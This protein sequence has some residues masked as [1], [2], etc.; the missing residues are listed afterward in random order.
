MPEAG[1]PLNARV[2]RVDTVDRQEHFDA[3]GGGNI[4]RIFYVEPYCAHKRVVIALKGTVVSSNAA[5]PN[6]PNAT[7]S[8]VKPHQDPLYPQFYCSDV[9]VVPFNK[10]SSLGGPSKG[11]VDNPANDDAQTGQ[12]KAIRTALDWVDD[13]DGA[14]YIDN[15]TPSEIASGYVTVNPDN[16]S[17][18]CNTGDVIPISGYTSRGL[19][20]AFV[21]ATYNPLIFQSGLSGG[22]DP[23]D[24]VDPQ[25]RPITIHSQIGRDL[26]SY[27]PY[28]G[29]NGLFGGLQD[30]FTLP[31]IMWEFSI[32]RI[33]VP[34]LPVNTLGLLANKIN[35]GSQSIGD[36]NFPTGTLR[37]DTPEVELHRGPDG[38]TWYNILL[39][40]IFRRLWHEYYDPGLVDYT[41]GWVDW[42]HQFT[43]PRFG[44]LVANAQ[45]VRA[46][47]YPITWNGGLFQTFGTNNPLY[48]TDNDVG[49]GPNNGWNNVAGGGALVKALTIA[50]FVTGFLRGQ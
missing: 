43:I 36:Q 6:D 29:G 44:V 50:P 24:A 21:I 34:F 9:Q 18:T 17:L 25:W 47:Y 30:T 33:M 1:N 49:G 38:N 7:W 2:T 23:F 12:L 15:M 41:N 28:L 42:N 16:Q 10:T 32:R 48:L 19:V 3:D 37:M 39:R 27:G 40:F 11:F 31:E 35:L 46:S 20:G 14:N 8:R 13:F 26:H 5:T 4:T 45:A 22:I